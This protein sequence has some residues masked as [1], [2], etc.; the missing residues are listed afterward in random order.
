MPNAKVPQETAQEI[1]IKLREMSPAFGQVQVRQLVTGLEGGIDAVWGTGRCKALQD[2]HGPLWVADVSDTCNGLELFAIIRP[3]NGGGRQVLGL[4]EEEALAGFKGS[5]KRSPEQ[6][7]AEIDGQL[8]PGA[9]TVTVE[10]SHMPP[11]LQATQQAMATMNAENMRLQAEV[12]RLQVEIEAMQSKPEDKVLIRYKGRSAD[13]SEVEMVTISSTHEKAS[14]DLGAIMGK[15]VNPTDIE[16][17][18]RISTPK[19]NIVW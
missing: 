14:S 9:Q 16:I 3:V 5:V 2:E 8:P 6:V 7:Q 15:G 12:A 13:G 11:E 1:L 19:I 10:S 17:C 18:S 4:V